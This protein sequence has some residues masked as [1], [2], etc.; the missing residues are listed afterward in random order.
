M[1]LPY[2]PAELHAQ[3]F[4]ISGKKIGQRWHMKFE[5]DHPQLHAAK[6]AKLDPKCAKNFNETVIMIISTS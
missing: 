3:T 2:S 4:A 5:T 1:G 6:P